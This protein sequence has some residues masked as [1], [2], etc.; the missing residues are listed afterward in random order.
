MRS[1][2]DL[3]AE[4]LLLGSFRRPVISYSLFFILLAI[5]PIL[6]RS[7]FILDLFF[8]TFLYGYLSLAWNIQSGFCGQYSVGHSAYFGIGAYTSGLLYTK[9][10]ISPWLGLLAGAGIAVMFSLVIGVPTFRLKVQY[11]VLAT[12]AISEILRIYFLI[13]EFTGASRGVWYPLVH[14]SM[15]DFQFHESRVPYYY[16]ALVFMIM[17]TLI[18][19]LIRKSR[20]GLHMLGTRDDEEAAQSIGINTFGCKMVASALSAFLTAAGG[21]LYSQYTLFIDPFNTVTTVVSLDILL[22][23][24]VGGIGTVAGPMLGSFLLTPTVWLFREFFGSDVYHIV[25]K[26]V[27]LMLVVHLIPR[28]IVGTLMSKFVRPRLIKK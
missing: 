17:G 8:L 13:S 3:F 4:Y 6:I 22:P 14:D 19:I 25:F 20:L 5:I 27:F 9:M 26:G 16:I 2:S 12:I 11:Y 24:I 10:G 21:V 18:S 7:H 1:L 28:G 23:S 15:W